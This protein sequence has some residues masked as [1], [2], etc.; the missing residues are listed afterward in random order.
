VYVFDKE[1]TSYSQRGGF[2]QGAGVVAPPA[3]SGQGIATCLSMDGLTMVS[4]GFADNE[5]T[6]AAWVFTRPI[7]LAAWSST[8]LIVSD[9]INPTVSVCAL[10][11]EGTLL[12]VGG[13]QDNNNTGAIWTFEKASNGTWSQ[14]GPKVA[15][16]ATHLSPQSGVS[17]LMIEYFYSQ[18][19]W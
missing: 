16:P 1:S 5:Y 13:S 17:L 12:V 2:V 10:N 14:V 15:A 18:K 9:P 3:N 6:G 11:G 7:K 8:K 4:M 19:Y